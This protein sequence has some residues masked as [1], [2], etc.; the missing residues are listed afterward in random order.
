MGSW[1][2]R[3]TPVGKKLLF[4]RLS[5]QPGDEFIKAEDRDLLYR[6][7]FKGIFLAEMASNKNKAPDAT[8]FLEGLI[9]DCL[10]STEVR[11]QPL[12]VHTDMAGQLLTAVVSAFGYTDKH[13]TSQIMYCNM[14]LMLFLR[15]A[16]KIE[17]EV[18]SI[19][20][21][22]GKVTIELDDWTESAKWAWE[23]HREFAPTATHY[24]GAHVYRSIAAWPASKKRESDA[25]EV[26]TYSS[27]FCEMF[28]HFG[29]TAK[30]Y[31]DVSL[32]MSWICMMIVMFSSKYIA[33]EE[34][35]LSSDTRDECDEE[36]LAEIAENMGYLVYEQS[37]SIWITSD[38]DL[39][40]KLAE[41]MKVNHKPNKQHF[42]GEEVAEGI[43]DVME[44]MLVFCCPYLRSKDEVKK[45]GMI[46]IAVVYFP[47]DD[48]MNVEPQ[49]LDEFSVE[50]P[51]PF[52]KKKL[53]NL[54]YLP[55]SAE[56][57]RNFWLKRVP[58]LT[59]TIVTTIEKARGMSLPA[60]NQQQ[61]GMNKNEK[62][63]EGDIRTKT[64]EPA[65]Y[66]WYRY[67][68]LVRG[69]KYLVSEVERCESYMDHR[70]EWLRKKEQSALD[71]AV[72]MTNDARELMQESNS[73][74]EFDR[75]GR[76]GWMDD[77]EDLR[78]SLLSAFGSIDVTV[79]NSQQEKLAKH[80]KS[81]MEREV[82][83]MSKPTY[84]K[85]IGRKPNLRRL[86]SD[87]LDII[88]SFIERCENGYET[89]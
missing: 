24:C 89:D 48:N 43:I 19:D 39:E 25:P 47:F 68:S 75:N 23:K 76:H 85:W 26:K 44:D 21:D 6:Q 16:S 65:V 80:G 40:T 37:K 34:Y 56:Y 72:E 52:T 7:F 27:Q 49:C 22:T 81:K 33:C 67:L 59:F 5:I 13:V 66:F 38:S 14:T 54:L 29:R 41:L 62:V 58:L 86:D 28:K 77:E 4:T 78:S 63:V 31:D 15:Q 46:N 73:N 12:I 70:K 8:S 45:T 51:L 55:A 82:K 42:I 10:R 3:D 53:K 88:N 83:F 2:L 20:P 87:Q 11:I 32:T 60:N 69:S 9:E 30:N 18:I 17:S 79:K 57:L 35:D 74:M 61:E 50:V 84:N 64:S 1:G 36:K 71:D